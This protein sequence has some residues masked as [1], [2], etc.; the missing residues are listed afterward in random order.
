MI[1][2]EIGY[3]VLQWLGVDY[4]TLSMNICKVMGDQVF[5]DEPAKQK[6]T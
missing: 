5:I 1:V 6:Q 4:K 3:N 2:N